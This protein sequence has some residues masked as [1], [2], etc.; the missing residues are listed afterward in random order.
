[1][2]DDYRGHER[3]FTEGHYRELLRLA[4]GRYRF[5][6]FQETTVFEQTASGERS[7]LWRHDVDISPQRARSLARIEA[8]EGVR[9]T[10]FVLLHAP[11]YNALEPAIVAIFEEIAA[12]GHD[13]GLHFDPLA[14]PGRT[15][16]EPLLQLERT[17]LE[18]TLRVPVRAFSWHEPSVGNW[19]ES[20]DS[21]SIGGMVNAYGGGLRERFSYLSDS[22]G[23][24]RF[25]RLHDVLA[26]ADE[27]HLHVLTHPEWWVEEPMPPR[28]RVTRAVAGR[29][30]R[31]E[32]D[33]DEAI[34]AMGR[35]NVR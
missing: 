26:A 2:N 25:R 21:S 16:L 5:I 3:D 32:R 7:I 13:I 4:K 29:A 23:I 10:Y 18:T 22:H 1:M 8:E 14:Y 15:E 34:A 30:L 35:P 9:S 12:L 11:M 17:V 24:W 20:M 33:Y 19:I 28:A 31:N 27:P 6:G